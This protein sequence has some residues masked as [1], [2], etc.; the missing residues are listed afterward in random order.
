MDAMERNEMPWKNQGVRRDSPLGHFAKIM[1][2]L[3]GH[4]CL[5][6]SIVAIVVEWVFSLGIIPVLH[7]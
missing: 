3:S 5:K 4:S 7:N 6:F 1:F 2:Q